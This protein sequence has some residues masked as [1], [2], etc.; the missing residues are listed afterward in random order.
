MV[1]LYKM[2]RRL[3]LIMLDGSDRVLMKVK[4]CP[5]DETRVEWNIMKRRTNLDYISPS[6]LVYSQS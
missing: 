4:R 3:N 1:P 2:N 5:D 6:L